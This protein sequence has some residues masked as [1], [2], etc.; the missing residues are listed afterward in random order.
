MYGE[1][2]HS[3]RE[4]PIRFADFGRLHR[5]EP[6]GALAGLTRVRS[7]AQDDGHIFCAPE[8][9]RAEVEALLTM[10]LGCYALFGFEVRVVLSTRPPQ[11]AGDD[12]LWDRAEGDL[13]DALAASG[14]AYTVNAG[15][16][17]F[18]GPKIDFIVRDALR[19]EHQLGTIQLDYVLPGRFDL[20]YQDTD[21]AERQPVM[22]HRAMLGSLE[23][24]MGILIEHRAGAFPLWLAPVQAR[25]L[26]ITS[27]AADYAVGVRDR[28]RAAGLRAEADVRNEKIGAKIRDAQ[29]AKV[30][31]ML[32]V[33]A[34]EV[35]SSQV[36][37]RNRVTGDQGAKPLADVIEMLKQEEAAKKS[38][39]VAGKV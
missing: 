8:H 32:V 23:R 1:G 4:L 35:E 26:A 28:L 14:Q 22:I 36:A 17:A 34:K 27:R 12:A 6:S 10:I 15:D 30:P 21:D 9:I 31:Y 2:R 29:L 25:V 39:Q 13:A 38:P 18:Y 37:V 3:Y 33:G 11:R 5:Y 16:G 7:F 24:F 19:R 20:H